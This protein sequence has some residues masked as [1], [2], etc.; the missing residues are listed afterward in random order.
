MYVTRA[1]YRRGLFSTEFSKNK[2]PRGPRYDDDTYTLT[3]QNSIIIV[4]QFAKPD[5][6]RALLSSR[7]ES[8]TDVHVDRRVLT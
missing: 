4:R 1:H 2:R 5:G 3:G 6:G 8:T 7:L